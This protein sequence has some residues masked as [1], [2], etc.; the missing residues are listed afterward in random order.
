MR[1]FPLVLLLFVVFVAPTHAQRPTGPAWLV[2]SLGNTSDR[3]ESRPDVLDTPVLPGSVI[4]A[5]TLVAAL[6]SH[7]IEPN[8]A[9]ICRRSVTV[10]GHNYICSHPDL[11]RPLTP[12][13]ALAHSCNDF[14]V[15]LAQGLSRTNVNDVRARVGL[16]PIS[17]TANFAAA[18]VGL[19]GP[20][21][22]PRLLLDS[23]TR[24]TGLDQTRPLRIS[25]QTRRVLLDGLRGAATYG[26]ASELSTRKI[27][28]LAK[29]G[30]AP[31]PGGG[32]LGL[33]IAF[34]PADN[35]QRAVLVLAPGAAGRDATS[36][37]GDLLTG[38]LA[39]GTPPPATGTPLLRIGSPRAGDATSVAS[40]E[41]EDYVARVVA[42][43][44]QARAHDA[45]QQALAIAARTFAMANRGRH[46]AEGFDLCDTTH[47][48]VLRPPT[49]AARRATAVTAG[50]VL[51]YK[52][53][54]APVFYSA[55]CG[56]RSELPSEVWPGAVD[57]PFLPAQRD[58]AC[59]AEPDWTSAISAPDIERALRFAGLKGTGLRSL[60]VAKRS[61][62]GRVTRLYADGFVPGELSGEEFRLAV[63]RSAG[64]QLL[65]STAFEMRRDA[66]G[67]VFT[68]RGFGHGVGM[69]VAGAACRAAAGATAEAILRFYYPGLRIDRYTLNADG[70]TDA[71]DVLL[72]LPGP[73]ERERNVVLEIIRRARA[74]IT[75]RAKVDAPTAIRVTVQPSVE[76]FHRASRQPWWVAGATRGAE[77]DL[78]PVTILR[79]RGLLERTIRHELAHV[80]L[81][82]A[83]RERL[84]WVREGAA[85]YFAEPVRKVDGA[86]QPCPTDAELLKPTSVAAQRDAY[87]RADACFRRQIAAGTRW[88]EVR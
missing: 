25:A 11:K 41:L 13:E 19:D 70:K 29:T 27:S 53:Q 32:S 35:P 76:S 40:L 64:W 18:L 51:L 44:G 52:G 54:P 3:Q 84:M 67:Y 73:E 42:G 56:G 22:A 46:S 9:R 74:D 21:I 26:S 78:L 88:A 45:A 14:F 80:V 39:T 49:P 7:V 36:I 20:R 62:S 37:A 61:G 72:A 15:S 63:G 85:S 86:I 60:R 58:D 79:Q 12:A 28:A 2:R 55:S 16:P 81:D 38:S 75:A 4:K 68:G 30:T 57:D 59:G 10:D 23:L 77:I 83:L 69:C 24:L 5:V 33:T 8:S 6:E 82:R 71:S 66:R 50:R 48:Q 43:E 65:K 31:L 34:A 87:G 47:C 17:S 1:P